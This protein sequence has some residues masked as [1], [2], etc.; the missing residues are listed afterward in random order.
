MIQDKLNE[1][2]IKAMSEL[3]Q[4][5]KNFGFTIRGQ[6]NGKQLENAF[7]AALCGKLQELSD[8]SPDD[9]LFHEW[10]WERE[11]SFQT[12]GLTN[13]RRMDIDI[14]GIGKY[15]DKT[16]SVTLEL[17]YVTTKMNG[18][19]HQSPANYL[20]FPY[21]LIKDCIKIELAMKDK[22][23]FRVGNG[24]RPCYGL[25]IGLT[26]HSDFWGKTNNGWSQHF[27]Q[28]LL[29]YNL[30]KLLRVDT[31]NLNNAVLRS[32]RN[33]ASLG[34]QWS[35]QWHDYS[36]DSA[37]INHGRFKYA[38]CMPNIC[39]DFQYSHAE[40][41]D[42][43]KFIPYLDKETKGY[44]FNARDAYMKKTTKKGGLQ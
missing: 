15:N 3:S 22:N 32:Y 29:Q 18:N 10:S 16:S 21:D 7:Q 34:Y 36:A 30:P 11:T 35:I 24:T 4:S 9:D 25:T 13:K 23:T 19:Q 5:N 39:S 8:K 1:F 43:Y 26:N 37:N 42:F 12:N 27:Q 41:I 31:P 44:F 28:A 2:V 14:L 33:H 17:K 40:A 6:R 38:L 20:A